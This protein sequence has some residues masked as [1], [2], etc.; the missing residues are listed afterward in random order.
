MICALTQ[1]CLRIDVGSSKMSSLIQALHF[2]GPDLNSQHNT[3]QTI[4]YGLK[5]TFQCANLNSVCKCFDL[6]V[7]L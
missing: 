1:P 7:T 5:I 6:I 4:F 2:C 3:H